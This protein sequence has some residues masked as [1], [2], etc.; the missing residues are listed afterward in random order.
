M[1]FLFEEGV[2][3]CMEVVRVQIGDGKQQGWGLLARY[4]G[5]RV[6]AVF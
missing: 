6:K 1:R 3:E 2:V 5:F 4:K